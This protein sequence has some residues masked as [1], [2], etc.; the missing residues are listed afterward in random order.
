[1][2]PGTFTAHE[3]DSGSYVSRETVVPLHVEPMGDLLRAIVDQNVELRV[4]ERLGPMWRRVY[5][6]S[7]LHFSGTRLR[8]ALGYPAEFGLDEPG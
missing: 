5:Q 3:D 1:M 4:V 2:P 8:N 7:T 6:E